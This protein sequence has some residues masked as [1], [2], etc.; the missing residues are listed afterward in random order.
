MARGAAIAGL[1]VGLGVLGTFLITRAKGPEPLPVPTPNDI[2]GS[3]TVAEL[4][5]Y[6]MYIGQLVITDQI[7]R[8]RYQ[9]LYD[10]YVARFYQLTGSQQ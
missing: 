10:A 7:D 5:I 2:M 8:G 3:D 9:V 4:D 6:F 1:G